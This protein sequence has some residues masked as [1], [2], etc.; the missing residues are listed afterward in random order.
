MV[1]LYQTQPMTCTISIIIGIVQLLGS[2]SN[3]RLKWW[4]YPIYTSQIYNIEEKGVP[5]LL[6]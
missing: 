1:S 5:Q 3:I 6:T 2:I 4:E